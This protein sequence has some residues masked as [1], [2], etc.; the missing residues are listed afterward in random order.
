MRVLTVAA[1]NTLSDLTVWGPNSPNFGAT[2]TGWDGLSESDLLEIFKYS[3]AQGEVIY[4][5][6]FQNNTKIPT[7]DKL[8]LTTTNISGG[9]YVDTSLVTT[10]D[11]L[12]SNGVLQIIDR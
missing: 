8:S 1:V 3:I 4:S 7:L 11:Y 5:S 6:E 12:T 2:F 9:F 10:T